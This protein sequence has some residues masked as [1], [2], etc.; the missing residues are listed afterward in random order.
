[1]KKTEARIHFK[2]LRSQ[3]TTNDIERQSKQLHDWLFSRLMMHRFSSISIY[4]P[5]KNQKEADTWLIINT[6][7]KDF[8]PDLYLP[9]IQKN[10]ELSHHLFTESTQLTENKWGIPEPLEATETVDETTF[11]LVFVPLLAFD[12][13]GNRVGYGGGYYD[14]FL[15]KCSPKCL[16]V[17]LSF[18]A[19]IEK[20][21]DTDLH[22]IRLDFCVTPQKIWTFKK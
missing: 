18:F 10:N 2:N 13:S 4:L 17:G 1:M 11:D 22:D 6:L 14:R 21:E 15:E 7:R 19:P 3:L 5:I 20:I 8:A 9:K 12:K 16:K